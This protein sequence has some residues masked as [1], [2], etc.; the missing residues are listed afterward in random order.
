MIIRIQADQT[1]AIIGA[2]GSRIRMIGSMNPLSLVLNIVIRAYAN[3]VFEFYHRLSLG[4]KMELG[5]YT[6]SCMDQDI[7]YLNLIDR[8]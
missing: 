6:T 4:R 3:A 5:S 2:Q 7:P 1:L 8:N